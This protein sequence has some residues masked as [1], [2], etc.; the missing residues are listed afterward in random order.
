M[1]SE[2]ERKDKSNI[3][4]NEGNNNEITFNGEDL[5]SRSNIKSHSNSNSMALSEKSLLES[6]SPK[7][8]ELSE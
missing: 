3:N 8:E 5:Y 7:Q 6:L 1:I 4:E 2:L